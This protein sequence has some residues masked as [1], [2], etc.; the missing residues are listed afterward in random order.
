MTSPART[1]AALD[2]AVK[3]GMAMMG[4]LS[5]HSGLYVKRVALAMFAAADAAEQAGG[6]PV[7]GQLLR[8]IDIADQDEYDHITTAAQRAGLLWACQYQVGRRDVCGY[9]NPETATTCQLRACGAPRPK[10]RDEHQ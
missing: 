3:A 10:L 7:P 6:T 5:S 9:L 2:A 4:V 1:P 8:L